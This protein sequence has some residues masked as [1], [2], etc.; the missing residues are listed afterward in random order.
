MLRKPFP[1]DWPTDYPRTKSINIASSR[2]KS[3]FIINASRN[4]VRRATAMH[5]VNIV[6][7]SNMP[8]RRDGLPYSNGRE[9]TDK[10]VAVWWRS[11]LIGGRE[12]VI[13]CDKWRTVGEN[14]HALE[15]SLDA[16]AALDRWGASQIVKRAFAGFTALP[17]PVVS[18]WRDVLGDVSTLAQAKQRYLE[19]IVKHHPDHGGTVESASRINAAW[20][21]AQEELDNSL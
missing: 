2:F 7:S 13:T 14:M 6:V 9:P 11:R 18:N 19:E 16:M 21:Q 15:L 3:T 17:P 12:Q 1:L 4:I 5:F 8:T 20:A 10:G